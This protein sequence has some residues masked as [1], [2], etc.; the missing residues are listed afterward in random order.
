[1]LVTSDEAMG[2]DSEKSV[3]TNSVR[4][5]P[6]PTALTPT[7]GSGVSEFSLYADHRHFLGW[8]ERCDAKRR[9]RLG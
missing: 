3:T 8:H 5:V 6:D 7:P 1:L 9:A 2:E 4:S